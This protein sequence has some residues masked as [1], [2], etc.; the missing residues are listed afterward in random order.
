MSKHLFVVLSDIHIKAENK[1]DIQ[2]KMDVFIKTLNA[3]KKMGEFNK[4][5][6]IASGDIAFSGKKEEYEYLENYFE[7]L[8]TNYDLVI[9]P[10]NHDH[11]FS[12]YPSLNTRKQLLKMDIEQQDPESINIITKGMQPFF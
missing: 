11:D 9:C 2:Y 3:R 1:K 8:A 7:E 12:S 10:G 5:I 6:I 4:I